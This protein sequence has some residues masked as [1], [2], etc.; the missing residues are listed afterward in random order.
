M[1]TVLL[2]ATI[3]PGSYSSQL[4][5]NDSEIRT[6][7]Y[8]KALNFWTSINDKRIKNIVFCENSG[9]DISKL[10]IKFQKSK[11]PIEFLSFDGNEKPEGVHYG[12]SELGI[13]DHAIEQSLFISNADYFIKSTGRL[14]FP[15]ISDLLNT[16]QDLKY[17]AVID[18]RRKYKNESG[19]PFKARTQL[20][21]F[22]K[23][24]YIKYLY[25]LRHQ[26]I[27]RT[28]H[29]EEFVSDKVFESQSSKKT[30]IIQRFKVECPPSGHSG[31][32]SGDYNSVQERLKYTMRKF[33]RRF[34]PYIWL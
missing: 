3:N 15:L 16:I 1:Y 29:L 26:M 12:Y 6:N 30:R 33:T 17:D 22:K 28:S 7:D 11:I 9:S 20:M 5:R 18:H 32:K 14:T 27:G 10:K 25:K 31:W 19:T 4:A 2:T 8:I 23:E 34:L 13:I 21:I 24:Y